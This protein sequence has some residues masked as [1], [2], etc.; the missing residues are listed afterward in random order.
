MPLTCYFCPHPALW[1]EGT[2]DLLRGNRVRGGHRNCTNRR[3]KQQALKVS[4]R[5]HSR[6][7]Q[8]ERTEKERERLQ[9]G[10]ARLDEERAA[11]EKAH[12]SLKK[13]GKDLIAQLAAVRKEMVRG[14]FKK[15]ETLEITNYKRV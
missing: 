10:I 6:A 8:S 4:G 5:E 7:A 15:Y 2:R 14:S 12:S 13:T 3:K 11:N 1:R 9:P